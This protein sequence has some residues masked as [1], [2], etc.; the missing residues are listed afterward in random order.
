MAQAESILGRPYKMGRL[1][2]RLRSTRFVG[3]YGYAKD[4][5]RKDVDD[6]L[7]RM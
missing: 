4:Q 5:V 6:W 7:N 2:R 3:R 1:H